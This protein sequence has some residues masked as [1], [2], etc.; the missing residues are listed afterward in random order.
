[1]GLMI[2]PSQGS[3]GVRFWDT[4]SEP[5]PLAKTCWENHSRN[6]V[7][8]VNHTRP[9]TLGALDFARKLGADSDGAKRRMSELQHSVLI[10]QSIP[11]D[12]ASENV[13][14]GSSSIDR[15]GQR[16]G[17]FK[18]GK[19]GPKRD[20]DSPD[21]AA[22]DQ[23]SSPVGK[24]RLEYL[25]E[26]LAEEKMKCPTTP[27]MRNTLAHG[28]QMGR[29]LQFEPTPRAAQP[30]PAPL[31]APAASQQRPAS[32][33]EQPRR[34]RLDYLADRLE[35]EKAKNQRM[36]NTLARGAHMRSPQLEP[37]PLP[38]ASQRPASQ[39][40][41]P[42]RS[43]RRQRGK[44]WKEPPAAHHN[45]APRL[46]DHYSV[47]QTG[48]RSGERALAAPQQPSQAE[49]EMIS[50]LGYTSGMEQR[51]TQ[52]QFAYLAKARKH[53]AAGFA[54]Q[55]LHSV[56]RASDLTDLPNEETWMQELCNGRSKTNHKPARRRETGPGVHAEVGAGPRVVHA[57]R[58]RRESASL[59]GMHRATR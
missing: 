23:R 34:S 45:E 49:Q 38:A 10:A 57:T 1:M 6:M 12:P 4:T 32:Q 48:R 14:V 3:T 19:S 24:S 17:T 25:E 47:S 13:H 9:S 20:W 54:V 31:P 28:A 41:Q 55:H 37:A 50:R 36:R 52:L 58:S 29:S 2:Q 35:E 40:E 7:N 42:R 39:P 11:D 30:E 56:A 8:P 27:Q 15:I 43:R 44:R 21:W 33:Q 51:A 46:S 53:K 18:P 16:L 59:P 22:D 26:R 5:D